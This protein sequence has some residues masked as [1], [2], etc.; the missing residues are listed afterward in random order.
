MEKKVR[1]SEDRS[2]YSIPSELEKSEK[3]KNKKKTKN[4]NN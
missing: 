1:E 2:S 4:K 3:K